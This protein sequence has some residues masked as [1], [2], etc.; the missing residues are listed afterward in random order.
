MAK[1][2]TLGKQFHGWPQQKQLN[3]LHALA[4]SQNEALDMMQRERDALADKVRILSAQ[5]ESCQQSLDIQKQIVFDNITQSNAE[6]QALIKENQELRHRVSV[7]DKLIDERNGG[8]H[9]A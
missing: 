1:L 3:H 7:Q 6:K 5:V 2:I 4:S 8:G 9:G